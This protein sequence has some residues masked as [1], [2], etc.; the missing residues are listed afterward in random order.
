MDS[1]ASRLQRALDEKPGASQAELARYCKTKGPSVSNWFT[2]ET[3]TLKA[4]SLVLAAEYLDV[5]PRWL[6]DGKGPMRYEI[7]S[8]NAAATTPPPLADALPVVVGRLPGLDDYSASKVLT[9]VQAAMKGSAPLETI[10]RD[11]LA[12]LEGPSGKRQ[13]AA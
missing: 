11:L 6:L 1:L 2:G 4:Q 3:R 5:R 10:E 9:A 7:R 13:A 8:A 12:L